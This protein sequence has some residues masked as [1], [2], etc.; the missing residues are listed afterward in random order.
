MTN[1]I[2]QNPLKTR[3]DFQKAVFELWEPL[4]PYYSPGRSRVKLGHTGFI[5]EATSA[6]LEGFA[7]PL[8][9]VVPLEKGGGSFSHWE[10]FQQGLKNGTN[11]A[12][13]EYWG[14]P[15]P[16]DQR[17]VEMAA[18]GLALALTPEKVWEP[19]SQQER[20]NL[21]TDHKSGRN[22]G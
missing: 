9:G 3:Q 6:E 11:P 8:W 21:A 17:L 13:P 10:Y 22:R 16:R 15:Q 4:K 7:R 2:A 5:F 19:F 14:K 18:I 20:E 1:P 12:H